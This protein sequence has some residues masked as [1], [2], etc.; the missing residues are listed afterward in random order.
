MTNETN[1]RAVLGAV[2]A[3]GATGA[4]PSV[5]R[6]ASSHPDAE[7]LALAS[8]IEAADR[9]CELRERAIN[10]AETVFFSIRPK[11]PEIPTIPPH[12]M[13]ELIAQKLW[14]EIAK[15]SAEVQKQ[16]A[17]LK[18]WQEDEIPRARRELGLL[19]AEEAQ[20]EADG[21]RLSIRDE[22][23]I[24]TRARTLEGLIFKA[25]YAASHFKEAYDEEVM[26]SIIDDLL[27]IAAGEGA[28]T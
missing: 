6:A 17:A 3:A 18:A 15:F 22:K 23:L 27:A 14:G 2:I 12:A 20:D 26:C 8:E 25:R 21:I 13:R 10:A 5:A 19:A 24:P 4:L 11:E 28:L 16:D 7:L 1:R 9:E